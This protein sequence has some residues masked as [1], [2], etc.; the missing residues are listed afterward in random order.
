MPG[1]NRD[2]CRVRDMRALRR[3]I[4]L[5]TVLCVV[6][7]GTSGWLLLGPLWAIAG[8]AVGYIL[9]AVVYA[10]S[11]S[12]FSPSPV[13]LIATGRPEDAL[14]RL[15]REETSSRRLAR[16]WPSQFRNVLA[17]DLIVKSDALHA[18]HRDAQALRSADEGV[19]I[20]QTLTSDKP[21]KYLPYLSRAIDTRS[22]ALACLGRQAEA[23][24][25]IETAIRIF[26]DLAI[27]G[28]GEYLPVLAEA[29]ACKAE[30]LADIDMNT[31]AMAAAH[32]AVGIYWHK[33][34]GGDLPAYAAQSALLEGRLLC[35]QGRYQ[36]ATRPLARGWT[37]ATTQQQH[38]L[39]GT[40]T[41]A[42]KAAYRAN[43]EDF[44][45]IWH[46]ETGSR[47]PGWL[48]AT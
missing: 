19:A 1:Q 37:L 23:I 29:L 7:L 36:E 20:Y 30:W 6:A 18:L 35:Q 27:A 8:V 5:A 22:R 2:T 40:G 44:T 47:P 39:L 16:A 31:E 24:Q 13:T 38:D 41:P 14:R 21:A 48:T 9:P 46:A 43:P 4:T 33:T 26:R 42:L 34:P 28:P 11:I 17:Y 45:T 12:Y 15:Q 25:A 10:V 3:N 32:E